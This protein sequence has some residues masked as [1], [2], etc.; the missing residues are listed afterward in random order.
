MP[1]ASKNQSSN[2]G[3]SHLAIGTPHHIDEVSEIDERLPLLDGAEVLNED[4]NDDTATIPDEDDA[5]F[6]NT[7]AGLNALEIAGVAGAKK[8]LGQKAVQRI[9]NGIWKGDI[10]FWETLNTHSTKK[11][12]I[13][14][15]KKSDPFCRLRVP[16]Y[17][18]IFE[19]LFFAAFLAFYYAVLVEKSPSHTVS[20]SEVMLYIWLAS[21]SYN[22]MSNVG[23]A[24]FEYMILTMLQSW[25]NSEML[26]RSSTSPTF[27]HIGIWAS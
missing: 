20:A 14:D 16:L 15:R 2:G 3:T 13:Y 17:L 26:A 18:K 12:R 10:I 22:G 24:C 19:V 25:Q 11:A 8:F 27:G 1:P 6:A 9:I 7:F 21:F 4:D 23:P 5:F